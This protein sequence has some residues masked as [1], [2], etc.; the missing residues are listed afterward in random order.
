M[1]SSATN[2]DFS[3]VRAALFDMDGVLYR[4]T[5]ALP[6]VNELLAFLAEQ[7]VTYACITNNAS[8]TREQFSAKLH[9]MGIN[10]PAERIIT[11]ATATSVWLRAR[12]RRG[13]TVFA[14][15]MDG[16]REALFAD[17]YF[18]EQPEQP[19]Y[20]VVGAD[21]E[22]TYAK[23]ATACLAIRAGATFVGTNPDTTFP[24]E[25]GIVPGVGA[26]IVALEAATE[27][28]A[29]IIGKPERAMFDTALQ[30]LGVTAEAALMVG[31]R[32][33]TDILGASR[34]EVASVMVLTGV[35][36]IVDLETSTYGPALVCDDLPQLLELWRRGSGAPRAR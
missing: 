4:G 36:S 7:Q 2:F 15:G 29:V 3:R 1:M 35:S 21:F 32:L 24:S 5:V 22:V 28:K 27:Q 23:L 9:E 11:S 33:D 30:L 31:D 25:R 20:V 34:A 19:E 14:I 10:V 16:L 13:T 18:A 17:G 8:R 12:A 26:L 6:G